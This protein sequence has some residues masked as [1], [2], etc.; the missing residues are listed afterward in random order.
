MPLGWLIIGPGRISDTQMA[1]GI[2]ASPDGYL[3]AVVSRDQGRAEAFAEKYGAEVATTDYAAALA[4]PKV[5]CV[6]IGTPNAQHPEQVTQA[7]RAGKHVLCDKPLA[8]TIAEAEKLLE[9]AAQTGRKLGTGFM[10]RHHPAHQEARRLLAEGA[11]GDVLLIEAEFSPGVS[12]PLPWRTQ[13]G[14]AGAEAL[15]NVTVHPLDLV[16]YLLADEAAEVT[17][18]NDCKPGDWMDLMNLVLLRFQRGTLG[19]V[20]ANQKVPN[21]RPDLRIYGTNGNIVGVRTARPAF[22]GELRV[23]IGDAEEQ[24]TEYDGRDAYHREVQAFNRAVIEDKEPNASALDGLRSVQI[25]EAV[26]R[27]QREGVRVSLTY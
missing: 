13:E 8:T 16:R 21:P 7:L 1:P 24:V 3:R 20:Q 4:D 14:L 10:S 5:D 2:T 15:Y 11:I 23:K 17:A 27:S 18:L 19:Y 26:R 9:V 12:H 6:F 25:T 22:V